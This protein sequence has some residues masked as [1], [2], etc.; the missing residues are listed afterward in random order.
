[1][2]EKKTISIHKLAAMERAKALGRAIR[3]T[4]ISVFERQ[5]REW[6]RREE[7][8]KSEDGGQRSEVRGRRTEDGGPKSEVQ[9]EM[10]QIGLAEPRDSGDRETN[11]GF[12][13]K[14]YQSEQGKGKK[15]VNNLNTA[16]IAL[17]ARNLM[18]REWA[19]ALGQRIFNS[20]RAFI[21][22]KTEEYGKKE[23]AE[24]ER[25][26]IEEQKT[27]KQRAALER[28]LR[29]FG[30]DLL[31]SPKPITPEAAETL[32]EKALIEAGECIQIAWQPNGCDIFIEP[33]EERRMRRE[34]GKPIPALFQATVD[35]DLMLSSYQKVKDP[36]LLQQTRAHLISK[37]ILLSFRKSTENDF[38][39]FEDAVTEGGRIIQSM[40]TDG[41][42]KIKLEP[43]EEMRSRNVERKGQPPIVTYVVN[44][45]KDL[46]HISCERI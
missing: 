13:W 27:L 30:R 21:E 5:A 12:D 6:K 42:W 28:A 16:S 22:R 15:K 4:E 19:M 2:E 23:A 10:F 29:S 37:N 25:K 26:A 33:W 9:D 36:Q 31:E 20:E 1:M 35:H 17:M 3:N 45:D 32:L 34:I 41:G 43:W 7:M 44:A 11:E 38:H 24:R 8:E 14:R 46:N 39:A 40:K 18:A